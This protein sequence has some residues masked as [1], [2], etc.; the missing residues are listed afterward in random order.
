MN[1]PSAKELESL[2]ID[3]GVLDFYQAGGPGWQERIN[4]VCEK[5]RC[6]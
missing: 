4:A 2:R 1:N 3:R 5:I 6:G